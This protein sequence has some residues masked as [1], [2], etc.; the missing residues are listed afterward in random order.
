MTLDL[1]TQRFRVIEDLWKVGS[2]DEQDEYL[3]ELRT[4]R[5]ELTKVTG[6]DTDGAVWLQRTVDR[7]TRNISSAQAKP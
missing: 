4:M 1:M 6:P 3:D 7:L 5:V 2:A